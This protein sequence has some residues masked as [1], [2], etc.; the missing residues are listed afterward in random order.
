MKMVSFCDS[1]LSQQFEQRSCLSLKIHTV[2]NFFILHCPAAERREK[3]ANSFSFFYQRRWLLFI[4]FR[5]LEYSRALCKRAHVLYDCYQDRGDGVSL[6]PNHLP[7]SH[8][9]LSE[10]CDKPAV[11]SI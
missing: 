9:S 3:F 2:E 8:C 10:A 1:N 6:S 5:A 4:F 7:A 11:V